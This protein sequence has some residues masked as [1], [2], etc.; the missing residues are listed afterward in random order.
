MPKSIIPRSS[1]RADDVIRFHF[2]SRAR[3]QLRRHAG[4]HPDDRADD[5]V[6]QEPRPGG[7]RAA[8]DAAGRGP[9]ARLHRASATCRRCSRCRCS[10][11]VVAT[12]SRMYRASEMT[13]WFASGVPL[14]PLRPA[15]AA[16]ELAGAAAD[17]RAALF[18]WPWQNERS[19]MLK[20]SSRPGPT[21]RGRRP[22]SSRPR[23]TASAPSSSR[24][25]PA[26]RR[27]A[28]T[29]SSSPRAAG[30][31]SVTVGAVGRDRERRRRPLPRPRTRA[32]ATSRTRAAARRR[33]R[34]SRPT[35]S[36]P[37][38]GSATGS[39]NAAAAGAGRRCSCCATPTAAQPR[40]ARLA[41]RSA[42][43]PRPTCCCSA[44]ACRPSNPRHASNWNLLFALLGF[45]VVL[46]LHQP[47]A[48]LD[49]RRPARPR[50]RPAGRPRRRVRARAGL[51]WWRENGMARAA[52]ARRRRR[53]RRRGRAPIAA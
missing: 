33:C 8:I 21:S 10:V 36:W 50:R 25:A 49:R 42:C 53:R 14:Q 26:T 32:S 2:A 43:W 27:P 23:A 24:A 37:A 19:A 31:E 48:G 41:A 12:L 44:S 1:K 20:N 16:H 3:A 5:H 6:H 40:R 39:E 46:Q 13:I 38:S 22:A 7:G 34:A 9:A 11:A 18:V 4:R 45:F 47:D 15:G 29:S 35:A 17:R 52:V 30:V 28:A 51:L